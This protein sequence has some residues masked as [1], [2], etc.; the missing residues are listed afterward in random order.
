MKQVLSVADFAIIM[1]LVDR[2]L[3]YYKI[4]SRQICLEYGIDYE[5]EY[6]LREKEL[7]HNSDYQNL[8][9]LKESLQN[10]NIEVECP[11]IEIKEKKN[12]KRKS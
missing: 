5:K 3:S 6:E 1:N 2:E 12:E 8:K 9:H 10:L 4:P 7:Q 11:D